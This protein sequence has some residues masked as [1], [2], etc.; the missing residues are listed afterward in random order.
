[1]TDHR[2][3][4]RRYLG[5]ELAGAKNSKTTLAVIE[6]YPKEN[7]IFLLDVHD[8]LGA[9]EEDPADQVLIEL[10]REH[11]DEN[12][13]H[14]LILGANVPVQLPACIGC[15]RKCPMPGKCTVPSVKWMRDSVRKAS[16]SSSADLPRIKEFTPYTQRPVE[17]WLRYSILP[18]LPER[19]RF[20]IDETLG[21]NKAP[22]T[23]RFQYIQK[24]LK[25]FRIVETWPKLTIACLGEELKLNHR[26][27]TSYRKLEEGA[28]AR[29][30]I[31]EEI[32]DHFGIFV[33]DRDARKISQSLTAFDAF[34]CALTALL[35]DTERCAQ[36][37]KGFPVQSGWIHYPEFS[38]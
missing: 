9:G 12:P 30:E 34:I 2:W 18:Q 35:S 25:G 14:S 22:L 7:K 23:A 15:E 33:Y 5:L 19:I 10:I 36:P 13:H 37:P 38:T 16:R 3:Q 6:Y 32:I 1:M 11:A 27:Q 31:L 17:L 4:P 24:H 26:L 29:T 28:H 21:G 20:D 8:K